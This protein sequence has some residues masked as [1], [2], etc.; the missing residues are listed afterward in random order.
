M[1]CC[2]EVKNKDSR[3]LKGMMFSMLV[4]MAHTKP[5][6]WA[7]GGESRLRQPPPPRKSPIHGPQR[8]AVVIV[9]H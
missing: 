4:G 2:I 7:L 1:T 8:G 6:E 9:K 5:S 3:D